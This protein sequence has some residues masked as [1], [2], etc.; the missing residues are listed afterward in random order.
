MTHIYMFKDFLYL[1]GG[2]FKTVR[3]LRHALLARYEGVNVCM[4]GTS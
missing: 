2:D 3:V 4:N 1:E